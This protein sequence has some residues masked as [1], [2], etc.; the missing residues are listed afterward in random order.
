MAFLRVI[1]VLPPMFVSGARDRTSLAAKMRTFTRGVGTVSDIGDVFLVASVKRAGVLQVDP[2]H[3]ASVLKTELG[4]DAAPVVVVRDMN[5]PQF[6]STVLSLPSAGLRSAMLAW[7]DD[8][9]D[10]SGASNVRDYPT[11]AG[12]ISDA[13][14]ALARAGSG[15]QVFAP[16]D[17]ESLGR[18]AGARRARQRIVSG[19]D[20][21]IAQP[22][23]TDAGP[24]LKRHAARVKKSG[25]AGRV[26]PSVFH[27]KG[28]EDVRRYEEMFGWKLPKPL[29]EAAQGGERELAKLERDV[30]REIRAEGF[31]GVCLSTRG[32]P[33]VA[34][35][36]LL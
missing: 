36:L 5:R 7:G 28:E 35:A 15:L 4:V 23:T 16:V 33:G 27:F 8:H 20:F 2:V 1:E 22:P 21:L 13:R 11:L 19:A 26:I 30:L 3:A 14:E 6:L 17:L 24:S 18:S 32:E 10:G 12:A 29:H 34:K 31:P 9:P 25:L